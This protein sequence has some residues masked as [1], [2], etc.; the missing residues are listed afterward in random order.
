MFG[1]YFVVGL[2]G[3]L[4]LALARAAAAGA[5]RER[6]RERAPVRTI[7][8]FQLSGDRVCSRLETAG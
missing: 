3:L 2:L 7:V 4:A 6:R 1:T 5:I 8:R